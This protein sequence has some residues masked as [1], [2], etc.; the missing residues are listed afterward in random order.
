[1]RKTNLRIVR[2]VIED[3]PITV[4][5]SVQYRSTFWL[6]TSRW[7]TL[8]EFGTLMQATL[9]VNMLNNAYRPSLFSKIKMKAELVEFDKMDIFEL[10]KRNAINCR[11]L[12]A[13]KEFLSILDKY[14]FRW[15]N[16]KKLTEETNW[17]LYKF[18][19]CY[20]VYPDKT[21]YFADKDHYEH[22]GQNITSYHEIKCILENNI[23]FK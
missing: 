10:F 6:F 20:S 23:R 16:G 22:I 13:A 18:N 12:G 4:S 11:T 1:M 9:F 3:K 14:G 17:Y 7:E 15:S 2:N 19:T 5:Y 21:I 8:I